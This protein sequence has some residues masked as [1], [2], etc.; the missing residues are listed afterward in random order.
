[1]EETVLT[2]QST[3]AHYPIM[4]SPLFYGA[5]FDCTSLGAKLSAQNK[6]GAHEKSLPSY[7]SVQE[8]K[9]NEKTS[10]LKHL[11]VTALAHCGIYED[12]FPDL[13]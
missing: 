7:C 8:K 10:G 9:G 2:A 6:V 12:I 1:M 11:R 4:I 5:L 13:V 3:S